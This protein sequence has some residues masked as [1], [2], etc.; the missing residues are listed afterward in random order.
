MYYRNIWDKCAMSH[1]FVVLKYCRDV[2]YVLMSL[3]LT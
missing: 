2:A 3:G 1:S